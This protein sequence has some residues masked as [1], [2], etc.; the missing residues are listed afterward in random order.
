MNKLL[1]E[2][3]ALFLTGL[4]G[5]FSAGAVY[6]PIMGEYIGRVVFTLGG[7]SLLYG[8]E[9]VVRMGHVTACT[10]GFSVADCKE[11]DLVVPSLVLWFCFYA[12]WRL[13][14]WNKT[15]QDNTSGKLPKT[16]RQTSKT[17]VQP[18]KALAKPSYAAVASI[19]TLLF[20]CWIMLSQT[21]ISPTLFGSLN[22]PI[23]LAFT[24]GF[25]LVLY[26]AA[27]THLVGTTQQLVLQLVLSAVVGFFGTGLVYQLLVWAPPLDSPVDA[28]FSLLTET[29]TAGFQYVYRLG[30]TTTA[31]IPAFLLWT[32]CFAWLR[33]RL[34]K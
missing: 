32:A 18:S 9:A 4:L 2:L 25:G 1:I 28:L 33:S 30:D 3:L 16:S 6:L 13:R 34:V 19:C 21:I 5:F 20:G 14:V 17:S 27:S 8:F 31:L 22:Y 26:K 11:H 15:P 24:V 7:M 29:M 10:I 23:K 12:L